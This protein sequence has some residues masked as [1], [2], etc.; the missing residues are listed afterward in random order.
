MQTNAPLGSEQ[1]GG[2]RLLGKQQKIVST[3]RANA[4]PGHGAEPGGAP[5]LQECLHVLL[6][7]S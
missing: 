4:S 3:Q 5:G 7:P 1:D 2:K 6:H